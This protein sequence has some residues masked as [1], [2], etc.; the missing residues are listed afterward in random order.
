MGEELPDSDCPFDVRR[1]ET[2]GVQNFEQPKCQPEMGGI[3]MTRLNRLLILAAAGA[4]IAAPAQ[5]QDA[6]KFPWKPM[7]LVCTTSPGSSVAVWCQLLAQEFPKV[8][9]QPM[10]V[11]FKSGGSQHE[12]VLYVADKPAD[13]HTLMHISAS[14]YGYFHLPHYTK[15]YEDDFEVLAQVE[16]HVYGVAVRC[17]NPWGIKDQKTLVKAAKDNC[18]KLAMG[19]NKIGSTHHRHQLAYLKASGIGDCVRFVPYQGDGDTVKDVVGGHL[20]IGQASPR[21]WRPHIEAGTV[22]PI[23]MKTEERL[24]DPH[25]KDVPTV[26]EAGVDYEIPHHWQ[27]LMLKK[28]TPPEI[29]AKLVDALKKVVQSPAYKDYLAKGTHIV[30]DVKTDL[31]YL[32]KDMA[33]NQAVVKEFMKEH[34]LIK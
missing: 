19:S 20:A 8:L 28:G 16:K 2:G 32:N 21:T 13:G 4:F 1:V 18:G 5:A 17:D 12:P 10:Q 14:F 24:N 23:V 11:V 6:S 30:L 25:W 31:D 33:E 3:I 34:K 29:R 9:G 7:E 26:K 22:C 15:T 27:G